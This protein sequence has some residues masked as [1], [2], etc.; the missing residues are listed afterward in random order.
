MYPYERSARGEAPREPRN[1]APAT[2][3]EPAAPCRRGSRTHSRAVPILLYHLVG[4]TPA[5]A[6]YPDLYVSRRTFVAEMAYL[7]RH[8]F[9]AVSLADVFAYWR[10]APLPARPVVL[11]FDDGFASDVSVVRP[12]L[13]RLRWTAT[14][15]LVLSHYGHRW[16]L[17]HRSLRKLIRAGWEIAS[18]SRTHPYLPGLSDRAL[19]AEVAGSRRFLQKHFHIP[20]SFFAYPSGG[21]D[22][23]VVAAVRRAG[24]RG[25]LTTEE[26]L[27]RRDEPYRLDRI[28]VAGS[29]D[30]RSLGEKLARLLP[31]AHRRTRVSCV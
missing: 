24:Y 10:G 30:A 14:L 23:R 17:T 12:I 29:D 28:C 19:K 15:D 16:G 31:R 11:T 22:A 27:A 2:S 3:P 20:V 13:E 9:E 8:G 21:Y 4:R 5:A 26:G 7:D 18:H 6:A 25:A 1:F